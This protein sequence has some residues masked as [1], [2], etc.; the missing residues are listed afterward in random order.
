[1]EDEAG[2]GFMYIPVD[3]IY[4]TRIDQTGPSFHAMHGVTFLQQKL[5]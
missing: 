1:M 5:C 4:A 2:A 3:M